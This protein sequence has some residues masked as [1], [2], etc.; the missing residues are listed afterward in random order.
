M[1]AHINIG[2]NIGDRMANICRAVALIRDLSLVPPRVSKV[3]ESEPWGY[4]SVNMFYNVGVEIET[5]LS[6]TLLLPAL[7]SIEKNIDASSHRDENGN[8]KDRAIDIDLIYMGD[9]VISI[10]SIQ[11]PHPRMEK[12]GFVLTPIAELDPTWHHP[13]T[14]KTAIQML[15]EL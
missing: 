14:G 15:S 13:V 12:R 2:S 7:K 3:F 6:P 8:Y 9:F 5:D 11:L 1:K 4:D 10:D